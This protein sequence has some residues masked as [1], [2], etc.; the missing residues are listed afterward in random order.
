[1]VLVSA[2]LSDPPKVNPSKSAGLWMSSRSASTATSVAQVCSTA[3]TD[4]RSAP[5][6]MD[7]DAVSW[8]LMPNSAW[9]A[10]TSTSGLLLRSEEHTSELQS[11]FDLVCRLLL[12][13]KK[14]QGKIT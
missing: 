1:M 8:K 10:S 6:A 2:G 12:E 9:P 13:K 11:R 14:A 7:I 4:F 3:S 5:D